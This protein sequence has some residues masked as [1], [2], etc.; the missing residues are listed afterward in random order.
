M[1]VTLNTDASFCPET[2]CG[3][4]AMWCASDKGR[5]KYSNRFR[6]KPNSSHEAEVMAIINGIAAVLKKFENVNYIIV[7]TDC[8]FAIAILV[9]DRHYQRKNMGGSAKFKKYRRILG[10]V[11]LGKSI[12]LEYRHVKAHTDITDART[13][14]NDWCDRA[15]K[16]HMRVMRNEWQ[17]SEPTPKLIET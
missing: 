6:E 5:F 12:E 2:K 1:L 3:G 8:K 14:V 15:A 17:S 11:L 13:Y 7:N 4:F 10:D 9:N 16:W